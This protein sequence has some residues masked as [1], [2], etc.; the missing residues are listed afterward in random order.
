M[1]KSRQCVDRA[2]LVSSSW[3]IRT[4]TVRNAWS[5]A[6]ANASQQAGSMN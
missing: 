5:F 4:G 1:K 3:C 6:W 2:K